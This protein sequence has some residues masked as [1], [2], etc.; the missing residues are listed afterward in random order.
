MR[1]RGGFGAA[2][3]AFAAEKY[4]DAPSRKHIP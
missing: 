1:W 4:F 3:L 2:T